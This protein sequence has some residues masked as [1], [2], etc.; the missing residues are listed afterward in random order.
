MKRASIT[1]ILVSVILSLTGC[2]ACHEEGDSPVIR[3]SE[4]EYMLVFALDTSPTFKKEFMEN[5]AAAYRFFAGTLEKYMRD[6]GNPEDRVLITGLCD[7]ECPLLWQGKPHDLLRQFNKPGLSSN[8]CCSNRRP[9]KMP[10][11]PWQPRSIMFATGLRSG[12][13]RPRRAWSCSPI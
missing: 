6:R 12:A 4:Y 1:T 2:E 10:T 5:D 9:P 8:S 13:Q 7:E 3:P 11:A